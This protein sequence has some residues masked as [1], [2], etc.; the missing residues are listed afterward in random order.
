MLLQPAR[1]VRRSSVQLEGVVSALAQ[2]NSADGDREE[3]G[4]WALR[5]LFIELLSDGDSPLEI[6]VL[7]L[8]T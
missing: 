3:G 5:S 1:D 2:E 7:A 8:R 6:V 4:V